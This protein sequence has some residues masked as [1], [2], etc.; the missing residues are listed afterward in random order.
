MPG[1]LLGA[2][3]DAQWHEERVRVDSRGLI[4]FYTDGVTEMA[5]ADD[6]FGRDRL[7]TLLGNHA[8]ARPAEALSALDAALDRFRAGEARDDVAALAMR[9]SS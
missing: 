2:F 1:P 7:R 6:R 8:G 3:D 5:G 9:P 4:L